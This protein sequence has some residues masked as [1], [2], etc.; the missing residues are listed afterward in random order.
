MEGA[1]RA[2]RH[3]R[4]RARHDKETDMKTGP[5]SVSMSY[6]PAPSPFPSRFSTRSAPLSLNDNGYSLGDG[7]ATR[8]TG[9]L[10]L[11]II[12]ITFSLPFPPLSVRPL[13][14]FPTDRE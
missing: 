3:D 13:T 10:Q 11:I 8:E 2:G 7:G 5:T 6:R 4:G 14:S 9:I 1:T 12:S